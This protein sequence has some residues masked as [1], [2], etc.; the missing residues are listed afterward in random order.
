[1]H[2]SSSTLI[3]LFLASALALL[4]GQAMAQQQP[5]PE[6][7]AALS[8]LLRTHPGA[9]LSAPP[10]GE[11][12]ASLSR[13]RIATSG[14]GAVARADDFL[15]RWG[16]ALSLDASTLRAARHDEV[17]GRSVV[18]YQQY[19]GEM[20]VLDRTLSVS[21]DG[22]GNVVRVQSDLL[23]M[24]GESPVRGAL[25]AEAA[26]AIALQALWGDAFSALLPAERAVLVMPTGKAVVVWRVRVPLRPLVDD[27]VVLVDSRD[28]RI[29]EQR[30]HTIFD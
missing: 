10:L 17:A 7:P 13:V 15:A 11:G 8:R 1:M 20:R 27:M 12:V 26:S 6:P 2:R 18:I 22:E 4:A 21:L 19:V 23:A 16:E 28:G 25:S 29:L 14:E 30:N 5:A 24:R 3:S 9:R